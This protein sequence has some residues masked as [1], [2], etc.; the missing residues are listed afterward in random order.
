MKASIISFAFLLLVSLVSCENKEEKEKIATLE[1]ELEAVRKENTQLKNN[2]KSLN[3]SI[4]RY[5]EVLKEIENN[6]AAIDEKKMAIAN[7]SK[8]N[9]SAEDAKTRIATHIE[10]IRALMENSKRKVL[11]LDKNLSELRVKYKD[12]SEELLQLDQEIKEKTKELLSTENE[13]E[14]LKLENQ[15]LKDQLTAQTIKADELNNM[16]NRGYVLVG[17]AKKLKELGVISSEGGFIGLGRVKVLK[18][19]LPDTAF[20]KIDKSRT[21]TIPVNAKKA[22]LITKHPE[23]SYELVGTDKMVENITIKDE[24]AFWNNGNYLVIETSGN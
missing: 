2:T 16:L 17:D 3:V 20:N 1:K 10:N 14:Q 11:T 21:T 22:K 8:E 5:K 6:L 15:D 18:S 23:G 24:K 4:E 19:N 9:L 13:L 12:Q 7:I